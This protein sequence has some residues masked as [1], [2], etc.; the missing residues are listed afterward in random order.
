MLLQT[1]CSV[2]PDVIPDDVIPLGRSVC[3][4]VIPDDVIPLGR[5]VCIVICGYQWSG[6]SISQIML[7]SLGSF[8]LAVAEGSLSTSYM[9]YWETEEML[10]MYT[11]V[12]DPSSGHN[13]QVV[14]ST[15]SRM[16]RSSTSF[17]YVKL[18]LFS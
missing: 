9:T 4:D 11:A 6:F 17:V 10:C 3:I 16:L 18:S 15:C 14:S 13:W 7:S 1:A 5:S 8:H 2:L 12:K